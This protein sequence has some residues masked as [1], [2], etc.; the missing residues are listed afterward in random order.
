MPQLV[1]GGKYVFGWTNVKM[2]GRI[3]MP[4]EAF[5]EY[6]FKM[7][8]KIILMS[9]SKTSGGFIVS[10]PDGLIAS[11]MGQQIINLLGYLKQSHAFTTHRLELIKS[12]SRLISWTIL[13]DEKN[14]WLSQELIESLGLQ[15]GS[16]LLVGRGSGLGPAFIAGGRIYDE[17]LKHKNLYECL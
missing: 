13:D 1:K 12:G 11:E 10:R 6:N 17:A 14:I 4:D 9:G 7:S 15:T 16:K 5:D 2:D 3:R 8:E